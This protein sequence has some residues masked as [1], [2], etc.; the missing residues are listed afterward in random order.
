MNETA[1]HKTSPA[2]DPDQ[3]ALDSFSS[4]LRGA[5]LTP[6]SPGYNEARVI[7]NG[8]ADKRPAIIV[9]CTGAADVID[10]LRFARKHG[11]QVAVR[12]GG[13][14]VA[15]NASCDGGLVIDLSGMNAVRVDPVARRAW[16]GG[17]ATLGDVDRE[18]QAFALA[19]PLGVVSQTGVA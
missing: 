1:A 13:H 16:V 10:A 17:G 12:G 18:T 2:L 15:G 14:N 5:C 3:E 4:Q 19:A 9:Q 11:L 8:L 6:S 7:W